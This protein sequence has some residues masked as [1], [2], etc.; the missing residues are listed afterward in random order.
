MRTMSFESV[1]IIWPSCPARPAAARFRRAF[2]WPILTRPKPR[3]FFRKHSV[4]PWIFLVAGLVFLFFCWTHNFTSHIIAICP[5]L[6]L[7]FLL[8]LE[9][10]F[11]A[12]GYQHLSTAFWKI[13]ESLVTS[14]HLQLKS[15]S[16]CCIFRSLFCLRPYRACRSMFATLMYCLYFFIIL[17]LRK[18]MP[19]PIIE[20]KQRPYG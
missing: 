3:V 5:L 11:S 15:S 6:Q 9:R 14:E 2:A 16:F 13:R 10:I 18:E 12:D 7:R 8:I 20:N 17:S 19:L 4:N 1:V